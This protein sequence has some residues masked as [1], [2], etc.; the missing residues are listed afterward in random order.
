MSDTTDE[1]VW[2]N[3]P[4]SDPDRV[5]HGAQ[6]LNP[7]TNKVITRAVPETIE[8]RAARKKQEAADAIA[9]EKLS[10]QLVNDPTSTEGTTSYSEGNHP[11]E[12]AA[13]EASLAG[14]LKLTPLTD[15][16]QI[17]LDNGFTFGT[18]TNH[19]NAKAAPSA[20]LVCT[21]P[22]CSN[23]NQHIQVNTDTILPVRCGGL[24][25]ET[26][27]TTHPC[28]TVLRCD[29]QFEPH[30]QN[31]GTLSAPFTDTW[32]ECPLCHTRRNEQRTP[33]P[34]MNLADL[35][36]QMVAALTGQTPGEISF[37]PQS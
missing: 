11:D 20:A 2:P 32:E 29:H 10:A 35:P 3:Y 19:D 28:G 8:D 34:P 26:D 21:N 1:I 7:A 36:V 25:T 4:D 23:L 24:V 5:S 14:E 16:E 12:I 27:S 17:E 13:R 6:F 33:L 30:Q 15:L 9:R 22:I 37:P 18:P 31:T